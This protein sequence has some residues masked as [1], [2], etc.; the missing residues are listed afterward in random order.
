MSGRSW[1]ADC[2]GADSCSA[3][4]ALGT[5][6]LGRGL[7]SAD[8]FFKAS[9]ARPALAVMTDSPSPRGRSQPAPTI[10]TH[11]FSSTIWC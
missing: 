10:S 9:W 3:E 7:L 8:G 11:R 2:C 1:P 4:V 6:L 5:S